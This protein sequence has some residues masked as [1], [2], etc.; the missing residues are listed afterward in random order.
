MRY[1]RC[2][3]AY[4][5]SGNIRWYAT[6][7]AIKGYLGGDD[8]LALQLYHDAFAGHF[9]TAAGELDRASEE[10]KAHLRPA[11]PESKDTRLPELYMSGIRRHQ[12]SA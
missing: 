6:R 1:A 12:R 2:Q 3:R 7:A 9:D 4:P 11:V 5:P 10:T 8:R